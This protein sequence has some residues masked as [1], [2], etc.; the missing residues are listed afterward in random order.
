[1]LRDITPA[2][3]T[4]QNL[5]EAP[6]SSIAARAGYIPTSSSSWVTPAQLAQALQYLPAAA[7]ATA[8]SG[9]IT[10]WLSDNQMA[11]YVVAAAAFA[12]A[13]FGGRRR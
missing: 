2:F 13:M 10:Q 6:L 11:V 7:T 4:L 8:A 1:M 5:P 3:T 9:G 12:L